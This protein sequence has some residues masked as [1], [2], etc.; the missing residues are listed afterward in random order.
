MSEICYFDHSATTPVDPAVRASMEPYFSGEFGNPSSPH[1]MG[2]RSREVV[3]TAREQVAALLGAKPSEIYFTS[4][5]TESDN[6]AVKSGVCNCERC[7]QGRFVTTKIEHH[8]MLHACEYMEMMGFDVI[9]LDVGPDGMVDLDHLKREVN[10]STNFV[11]VML[12]NNEVGTVQPL[13]EISEIARAAGVTVHTDAVQ[14]IG[15]IPVDVNELGLDLLSLSA[16]KFYGPKGIGALYSRKGHH[17]HPFM[18][19]GGQEGKVRG[20]THNVPAIVGL[21]KAAELAAERLDETRAHLEKLGKRVWDGVKSSVEEVELSGAADWDKRLPGLVSLIVRGIEGEA[22]L[23]LLDREGFEASSGSACTSGSLDPSHVLTAMGYEAEVAHGSLR[24]SLGRDNTEAQVDRLLEVFPPI[25]NKL[26]SMSSRW[27]GVKAGGAGG[28]GRSRRSRMKAARARYVLAAGACAALAAFGG[29]GPR[30]AFNADAAVARRDPALRLIALRHVA[31]TD[32]IGCGPAALA[33]VLGHWK[34]GPT[35]EDIV[36]G[37][38]ATGGGGGADVTAGEIRDYAKGLGL[39]ARLVSWTTGALVRSVGLGRPVIVAR[40]IDGE[41]HFEVVVGYHETRGY[42][43]IDDPGRGLHRIG[44]EAFER[45]WSA[46]GVGRLALIVA[47]VAPPAPPDPPAPRK[48][49]P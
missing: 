35:A 27:A 49:A 47:P 41:G 17:I 39:G 48:E 31:Q 3:E 12:G 46:P 1:S 45:D 25:V 9:F 14:A 7:G 8:A 5:G 6:W 2:R 28:G 33:M 22:M 30:A 36:R 19:G 15:K 20:G 21:G 32:E 34:T 18:H 10:E 23:L 43:V 11:S 37:M 24:I 40:T 13:A 4:G 44:R 29:C 38:G 42:F 26:R 16:H